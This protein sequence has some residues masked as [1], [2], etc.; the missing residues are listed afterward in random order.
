MST[1]IPYDMSKKYTEQN[2][3]FPADLTGQADGDYIRNDGG[4]W[5]PRTTFDTCQHLLT[6][7][8]SELMALDSA[9]N[10]SYASGTAT[11]G[12]FVPR[13]LGLYTGTTA[14]SAITLAYNH[15]AGWSAGLGYLQL[16]WS[17]KVV[18]SFRWNVFNSIN[19]TANSIKYFGIGGSSDN[20][21]TMQGSSRF[22]GVRAEQNA[23][24]AV[25]CN[26]DATITKTSL[27][28]NFSGGTLIDM[29]IISENGALTYYADGV[30]LLSVSSGG[31]TDTGNGAIK[32]YITNGADAVMNYL[33]FHSIKVLV[34]Q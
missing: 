22:F 21:D 14:N 10:Y 28:R 5:K 9:F 34:E 13:R 15:R 26:N 18:L 23:M 32:A 12:M 24:Y 2:T 25:Y 33:F 8:E 19:S 29:L 20:A 4:V 6:S 11:K 7:N 1:I 30:E 16:N 3:V 27:G 17:K 31:P